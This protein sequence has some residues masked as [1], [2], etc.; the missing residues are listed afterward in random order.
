MPDMTCTE[1]Q[2]FLTEAGVRLAQDWSDAQR[3]HGEAFPDRLPLDDWWRHF[4]EMTVADLLTARSF[5]ALS[6]AA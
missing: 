3:E 2:A 1:F 5:R 6:I 4:A